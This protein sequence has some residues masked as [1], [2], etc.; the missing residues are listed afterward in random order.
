M[1]KQRTV[2]LCALLVVSGCGGPEG[3]NSGISSIATVGAG[4]GVFRHPGI[5]VNAQQLDFVKAKIAA[6]AEPWT[7]AFNAAEN[8]K[9]GALNYQPSPIADVD[10]GP[11][12]NPDV[13]CHAEQDDATAA[14]TQAL[15]WHFTGNKAYAQTAI[16]ILNAWSSTLKK[17][18]NS[19]APLQSAWTGAMFPRAAEIL[20]SGKAG[21]AQAD[22]DRFSHM[23]KT[24]HLPYIINGSPNDNG[25]WELTMAEAVIAIGVFLDDHTLFDKG[26]SM[27]RKRVPAYIYLTSDGPLPVPPPGGNKTTRQQLIDYWHGQSTF[28]D[29]LGQETCRDLGHLSLGFAEM[30]NAAETARIQG[31]DLYAEQQ[32]RITVGFEFNVQFLDGVTAPSWLCGGQLN[33]TH[34]PIWEI[35]YN[36]Y[37]NRDGLKLPH[38]LSVL[39]KDRPSGTSHHIAWETLTH[40]EVGKVGIQ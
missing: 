38:T 2:V 12:S 16:R 10:C 22:I 8:S 39:L 31:L 13:G 19:N 24:A 15:L 36:E 23:L 37:V 28:V 4:G 26:V 27:W 20:R 40:A 25:N 33:L 9:F 32:K 18:T 35:G 6:G 3:D 21:W 1:N 7:T 11:F 14:Y 30:I 29:G 34:S 17:H 5:L